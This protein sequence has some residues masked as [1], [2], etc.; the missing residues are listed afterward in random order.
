MQFKK[1][2]ADQNRVKICDNASTCSNMLDIALEVHFE[3]CS[4]SPNRYDL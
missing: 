1:L 4:R 3:N 2:R